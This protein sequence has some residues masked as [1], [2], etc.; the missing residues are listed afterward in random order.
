VDAHIVILHRS[1]KLFLDALN[2]LCRVF[3][4]C[5]LVNLVLEFRAGF[6]NARMIDLSSE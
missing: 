2:F 1:F 3:I 6:I 5:A 4:K